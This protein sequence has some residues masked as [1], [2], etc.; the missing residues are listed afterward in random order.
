MQIT[1]IGDNLRV[2]KVKRITIHSGILKASPR[3]IFRGIDGAICWVVIAIA[4]ASAIAIAT[5]VIQNG[6]DEDDIE[7]RLNELFA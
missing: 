6:W 4:T 7:N 3:F 1:C 5:E 2:L